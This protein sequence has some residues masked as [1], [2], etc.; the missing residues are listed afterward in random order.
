MLARNECEAMLLEHLD[1]TWR[2][3]ARLCRRYHMP[4]ADTEDFVSWATARLIENDYQVLRQFRGESS[5][6]TYLT[7]VLAMF[8]REYRAHY[9]G[10][11]RPCARARREGGVVLELDR[12]IR[13]DGVSITHAVSVVRARGMTTMSVRQLT[14][15]AASLPPRTAAC[16]VEKTELT[17]EPVAP[18]D[19][20]ETILARET[21]NERSAIEL[22]LATALDRLSTADRQIVCLRFWDGL[23]IAEISRRLDVPQKPLY[24]RMVRAL[25]ALRRALEEA[26]VTPQA[27]AEMLAEAA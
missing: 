27:A 18:G 12:L 11:W 6:R 13:R 3:M 23:T 16:G 24:R 10:R 5:L 19:A 21:A 4:E 14:A 7:V 15:I 17:I 9:W 1:W 22:A 2:S 8:H 26:G 25:T 20:D